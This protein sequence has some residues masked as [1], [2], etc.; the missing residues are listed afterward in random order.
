MAINVKDSPFGAVGNGSQ[1]DAPAIQRAVDYAKTLQAN[2]SAP[3]H[4]TIYFPAGYYVINSPINITGVTGIWLAGDGGPYLSSIIL[5]NTGSRPMFDFTGSSQSGCENFMF[6]AGANNPPSIGVQFALASTGGGLNCGIKR[7][8]FQMNDVPTANGGMGSI[9]LLNVRS[10]EFY[11]HECLI[12]ANVPLVMSYAANIVYTG[13]NYTASSAF[14]T[15]AS[16]TGSMGVTSVKGTSLQSIEKRQPGLILNGTNSFDFQ[17]YISRIVA[18]TGSNETAILCLNSTI[19]FRIHATIES[20]SR[21][22]QVNN[23]GF[24]YNE[25]NVICAN[26]TAPTTEL[27]DVTNCIVASFRARI[28]L[29]NASEQVNRTVLYHAPANNGTQQVAGFIQNSEIHCYDVPSNTQIVSQS[30]LKKSTNVTFNTGRPFEK[31]SNKVRQLT[32]NRIGAGTLGAL[33]T[34]TIFQFREARLTTTTANNSGY[35]RIQI[36]GVLKAGGYGS[37]AAATLCFEA[38]IVVNQNF[39]GTLDPVSIT[40]VILDQSVSNPA[41]LNINGMVLDLTFSNGIGSVTLMPRVSGSG[42]GEAVYYEGSAEIQSDFFVNDP[43]PL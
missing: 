38:Q 34:A 5:G 3:Y 18:T 14:Q 19:N 39:A 15:L 42:T 17:G 8:N 36:D 40:T 6:F 13:V 9:G 2:P 22:L 7:C 11:I 10:E 12:R 21:V 27:I 33:I 35:Y 41:Y 20:F 24:A 32:N 23:T 30:L 37:G 29:P 26:S 16:G 4:A 31:K 25:L 43:I 28:G 1:D